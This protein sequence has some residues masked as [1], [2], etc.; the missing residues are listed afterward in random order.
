MIRVGAQTRLAHRMAWESVNGPIPTGLFVCHKCDVRACVNVD[1]LFLGTN[2]DNVADRDKKGRQQRGE[3]HAN[4]RLTSEIVRAVREA[5][6]LHRE[7]AERFSIPT[8]HV[9][10]IR[11]RKSWAHV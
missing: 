8:S 7:I 6:G 10:N 3:R 9:T 5:R 4:A 2:A 1:H 11:N